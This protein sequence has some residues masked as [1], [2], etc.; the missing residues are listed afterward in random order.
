MLNKKTSRREVLKAGG[1]IAGVAAAVPAATWALGKSDSSSGGTPE[2]AQIRFI[3]SVLA[4][5]AAKSKTVT[6]KEITE[7]ATRFTEVNGVVDY[8]KQFSTLSGEYRLARLFV[9]S[10]RHGVQV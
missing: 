4:K 5:H 3:E 1:K 6:R 8:Q 2:T 7:F 9:R 10:V